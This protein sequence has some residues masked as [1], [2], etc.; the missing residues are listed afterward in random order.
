MMMMFCL[1]ALLLHF[2]LSQSL[3]FNHKW[4]KSSIQVQWM[5]RVPCVPPVSVPTIRSLHLKASLHPIGRSSLR[6][7]AEYTGAGD[8]DLSDIDA[9]SELEQQMSLDLYHSLRAQDEELLS[10]CNFLQWDDVLEVL[11]RGSI[12]ED[13]IRLIFEEV[14]ITGSHLTFEQFVEAVDLINQVEAACE[15]SDL[16]E[17]ADFEEDEEEEGGDAVADGQDSD[18]SWL[19]GVAGQ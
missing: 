8:F 5:R 16:L 11:E 15:G 19:R 4:T 17:D 18:Y 2:P 1:L 12:D 9:D 14:G 13:T 3:L 6:L 10:V 7:H